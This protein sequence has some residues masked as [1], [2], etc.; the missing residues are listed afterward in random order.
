ML[1]KLIDIKKYKSKE[2]FERFI[3]EAT[4]AMCVTGGFDVTNI[5]KRKDKHRFNAMMCYCV[6]K[7][8]QNMDE[9]HYS[10]GSDKKLY[11]YKNV[12]T[13]FASMG[14]DGVP[15]WGDVL[16]NDSFAEF[17]KEYEKVR[18]YCHTNCKYYQIE[19]A[20]ISTSAV[21]NYPFTSFSIDNSDIFWDFFLLWGQYVKEGAKVKLNIT[22]RFHHAIMDMQT[23]GDFF[24]ELQKQ[25]N[26]FKD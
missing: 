3:N 9:F 14:K 5:Y 15:Y 19:G 26:A 11:Y 24:N 22:L 1:K 8:A 23:A 2:M 16:Y 4:P 20:L 25:F 6:A 18:E 10:I 17:E 21:T 12:K 13:N 7:A